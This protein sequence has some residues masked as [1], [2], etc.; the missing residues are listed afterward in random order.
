MLMRGSTEGVG[1]GTPPPTGKSQ[2]IIRVFLTGR[3]W[4]RGRCVGWLSITTLNFSRQTLN[5]TDLKF[6]TKTNG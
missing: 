1:G 6:K 5:E 2:F 3:L 4:R